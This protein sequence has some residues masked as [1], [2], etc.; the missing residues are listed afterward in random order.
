MVRKSNNE[1][2]IF[3]MEEKPLDSDKIKI[4]H[5][6]IDKYPNPSYYGFVI[7][8]DIDMY[9]VEWF[10][11]E[12]GPGHINSYWCSN[13]TALEDDRIITDKKK[14]LEILMR[15]NNDNS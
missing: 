15:V 13:V 4:G 1:N 2:G 10:N 14:Q 11:T 8:K 5:M 12:Y 3:M 7:S 9:E 6:I